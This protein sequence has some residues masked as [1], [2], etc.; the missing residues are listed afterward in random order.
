MS[1]KCNLTPSECRTDLV[2]RRRV[3][4]RLSLY[5]GRVDSDVVGLS[6]ILRNAREFRSHAAAPV[7]GAPGACGS[8]LKR[9]ATADDKEAP[10]LTSMAAAAATGCID[11]VSARWQSWHTTHTR[12]SLR[13]PLM[14]ERT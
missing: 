9:T 1:F 7:Y 4:R 8:D 3:G 5:F 12:A 13:E 2:D 6:W 11:A 10:R 14:H